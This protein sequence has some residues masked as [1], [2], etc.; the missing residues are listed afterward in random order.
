MMVLK[1]YMKSIGRGEGEAM[2]VWYLAILCPLCIAIG[3]EIGRTQYP[4]YV[5]NDVSV[6]NA[7][8]TLKSTVY[9]VENES[10]VK[11]EMWECLRLV[12]K[13]PIYGVVDKHVEMVGVESNIFPDTRTVP[14][15]TRREADSALC[16]L[17]NEKKTKYEAKAKAVCP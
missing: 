12:N 13:Y 16:W 17:L 2:K 1:R 14:Y 4:R 7:I 15:I 3:I 10:V 9:L 5:N 8:A 6:E 11:R